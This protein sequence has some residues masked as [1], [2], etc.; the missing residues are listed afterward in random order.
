MVWEQVAAPGTKFVLSLASLFIMGH[1]RE[2]DFFSN[3]HTM[4]SLVF[5]TVAIFFITWH[6]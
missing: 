2:Y 1:E 4:V 3:L 5:D 6:I